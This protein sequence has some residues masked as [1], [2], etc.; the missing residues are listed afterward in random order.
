VKTLKFVWSQ[1]ILLK[2]NAH[3]KANQL[4]SACAVKWNDG[5]DVNK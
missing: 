1:T 4:K 5:S 2:T 3:F